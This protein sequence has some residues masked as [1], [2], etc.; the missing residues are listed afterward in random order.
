MKNK[1]NQKKPIHD[2]FFKEYFIVVYHGDRPWTLPMS[3][4]EHLGLH[5]KALFV[6]SFL[7][8]KYRLLDLRKLSYFK[9]PET[10]TVR[11][12]LYILS[13]IRH[14]NDFVV[15]QFFRLC[16]GLD[17]EAR[18]R[19]LSLVWDY[20]P[21]YNEEYNLD[22][23]SG[24]ESKVFEKEDRIMFLNGNYHSEH[25]IEVTFKEN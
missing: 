16:L 21:V 14:L 15:E 7:N 5:K 23:L 19:I 4:H 6:D 1:R 3:F 2:S 8:Y 10:L 18:K 20:V 24:I 13:Q 17:F 12:V 22:K 9:M 25:F 11:P